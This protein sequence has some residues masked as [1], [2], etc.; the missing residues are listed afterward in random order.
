VAGGG[1]PE[2][3]VVERR[4]A[5]RHGLACERLRRSAS[6]SP[7]VRA[8]AS[9]SRA[10]ATKPVILSSTT[11]LMPEPATSV[12]T[13]GLACA[14]ASSSTTPNASLRS[15]EGRQRQSQLCSQAITAPPSCR[16]SSRTRAATPNS[17]INRRS[18]S[19][20][21]PSPTMAT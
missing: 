2:E 1:L 17:S 5:R 20:R 4:G 18:G 10:G 21:S 15:T 6:T 3:F 9:A 12:T 19:R 11:Q 8:S 7:K 16:P 14:I 13:T